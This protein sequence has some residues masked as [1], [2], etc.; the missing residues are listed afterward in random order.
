M[1]SIYGLCLQGA[2]F[3]ARE[4]MNVRGLP[5]YQLTSRH[6][7][8]LQIFSGKKES[9]GL[10]RSHVGACKGGYQGLGI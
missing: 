9:C 4:V 10:G 2:P 7:Q 6:W 3:L 8:V 5:E 1:W